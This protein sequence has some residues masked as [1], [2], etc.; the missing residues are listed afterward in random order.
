VADN[1]DDPLAGLRKDRLNASP[2]ALLSE[3]R[4]ARD[5][6][7]EAGKGTEAETAAGSVLVAAFSQLDFLLSAGGPLPTAWA[8]RAPSRPVTDVP[9]AVADQEVL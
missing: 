9:R 6:W 5:D 1:A 8:D 3:L 2:D 7:L 4:E